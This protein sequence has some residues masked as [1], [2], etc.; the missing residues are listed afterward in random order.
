M[1]TSAQEN[2]GLA[3][4]E[5]FGVTAQGRP[6]EAFVIRQGATLKPTIIIEAGLRARYLLNKMN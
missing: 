4:V 2:P 3:Q 6:I 5:Q 1:R